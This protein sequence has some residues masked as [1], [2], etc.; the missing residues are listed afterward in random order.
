MAYA[1]PMESIPLKLTTEELG[2][3]P[4]VTAEQIEETLDDDCFGKFAVLSRSDNDFVQAGNLWSPSEE[5][6]EF[7]KLHGSDP[8]VLQY[9][10]SLTGLLRE[11]QGDLTM[12]QVKLVFLGYLR[13]DVDWRANFK[14]GDPRY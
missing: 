13:D 14:W 12:D 6:A 8:W 2:E 10:D 3:F 5:C 4:D 1:E 11:A 7:L 9:R